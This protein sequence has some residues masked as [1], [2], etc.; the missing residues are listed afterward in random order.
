MQPKPTLATHPREIRGALRDDSSADA[1]SV[2]DLPSRSAYAYEVVRVIDHGRREAL[3]KE[4]SNLVSHARRAHS[5]LSLISGM[6]RGSDE[7]SARRSWTMADVRIVR[8]PRECR[9]ELLS[10]INEQMPI[11]TDS[12]LAV[13]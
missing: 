2:R 9:R 4:L 1:T 3:P 7:Y 13:G 12:R 10:S 5:G 6:I 8:L 11:L